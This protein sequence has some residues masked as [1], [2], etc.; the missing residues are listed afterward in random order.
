MF[1]DIKSL[2]SD[3]SNYLEQVNNLWRDL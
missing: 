2:K 3:L 1:M